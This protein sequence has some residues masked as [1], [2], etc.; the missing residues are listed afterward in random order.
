ML[1]DRLG[2]LPLEAAQFGAAAEVTYPV[3]S[4]APGD[5]EGGAEGAVGADG[6][7][8]ITEPVEVSGELAPAATA[9][10]EAQ[11]VP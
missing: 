8:A 4:P 7:P 6:M 1:G 3:P 10:Q 5:V 11:E 2:L 9:Q